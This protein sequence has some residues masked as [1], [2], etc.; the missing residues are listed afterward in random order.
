[1]LDGAVR[2][3]HIVGWL[4]AVLAQEES[5]N[6]RHDYEED[7]AKYNT[8]CD[9]SFPQ[10][11]SSVGSF[12]FIMQSLVVVT[13]VYPSKRTNRMVGKGLSVESAALGR[14]GFPLPPL[15]Q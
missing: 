12:A 8:H 4:F 5:S 13:P 11:L 7:E 15:L 1:M 14:A 3:M 2:D 9:Y 6:E 10:H